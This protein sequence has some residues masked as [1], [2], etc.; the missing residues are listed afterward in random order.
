AGPALSARAPL[1]A[2]V[3]RHGAHPHPAPEL[4]R[5]VVAARAPRGGRP[6]AVVVSVCG[7]RRDPQGTARQEDALRHAGI[8]VEPSAALAAA[9][10]AALLPGV[11]AEVTR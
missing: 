3:L 11:R 2:P 10:A 4:A 5:C 8:H 1:P 7:S 6:L 9:E